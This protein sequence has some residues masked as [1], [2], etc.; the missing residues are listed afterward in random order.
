MTRLKDYK[1]DYPT[2]MFLAEMRD[3]FQNNRALMNTGGSNYV[4]VFCLSEVEF[5][6]LLELAQDKP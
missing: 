2:E 1:R 5:A 4:R 3:R 6:R